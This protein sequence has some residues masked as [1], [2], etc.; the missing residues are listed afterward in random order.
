M[1]IVLALGG[2][3]I[4][5]YI[6]HDKETAARF[7]AEQQRSADRERISLEY[8][9]IAKEI[10]TSDKQVPSVLTKW[11]WQ[12]IDK[13][14]PRPFDPQDLKSLIAA[15]EKIPTAAFS[16]PEKTEYAQ[17][18]KEM[19]IAVDKIPLIN[20][21][22]DHM[23]QN[24]DRYI[25]AAE[26]TGIPWVVIA[27]IHMIDSD[28]DFTKV[29]HNGEDPLTE[30][31]THVPKGRGPF[32]SWEASTRDAIEMEHLNNYKDWDIGAI[33][34][35]IE[36]WNGF[37]YRSK[38]V[39]SPYLWNCSNKYEKGKYV[40]EKECLIR[41]PSRSNAARRRSSAG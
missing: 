14:S 24:K 28:G 6:E 18:F 31:T 32:N 8:V 19:K 40:E 10:L 4:Q 2:W 3:A 9:K 27:L 26:G 13:L 38:N 30:P 1:P 5:T 39:N 21:T 25:S 23:M 15:N 35:R 29:F 34:L 36:Q 16:R 41:T 7:L 12:L 22:I 11:S 37:G 20:S 33:L 17:L